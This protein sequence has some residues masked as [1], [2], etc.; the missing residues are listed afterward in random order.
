MYKCHKIVWALKIKEIERI[1]KGAKITPA[2]KGFD[3]FYVDVNY[4]NRHQPRV[5]GY[6]V[7]Y[8]DGYKSFSPGDVFDDGYTKVKGKA[9]SKKA[10][11]DAEEDLGS[12]EIGPVDEKEDTRKS[13]APKTG[14]LGKIKS[15]FSSSD[16][17][18]SPEKA[19]EKGGNGADE[20]VDDQQ[21]KKSDPA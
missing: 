19:S 8:E 16:G 21:P 13:E 7:V 5:G 14:L 1:A 3:I 9:D 10:D 20:S 15:V 2:E 11:K 12:P 17:N 4:V 18:A 6:Y